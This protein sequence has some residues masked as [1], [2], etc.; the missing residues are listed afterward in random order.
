MSSL[1]LRRGKY[2][3]IISPNIG[4]PAFINF[5]DF[6]DSEGHFIK[7]LVFTAHVLAIPGQH[8]QEILQYF[9]ANT[10]IQPI[11]K[12]EGNFAARRGKRYELQAVE[13]EGLDRM[14]IKEP[15][16]LSVEN[17]LA[18][19][20]YKSLSKSK[21]AFGRRTKLYE[22]VFKI[23][24]KHEL[25]EIFNKMDNSCLLCDLVYDI[26][27]LSLDKVNYHAV[28]FFDK[29]WK[30]FNFIHSTDF[31]VARRNDFIS[32]FLK[33]RLFQKIKRHRKLSESE[34]M[35]L[36]R[37]FAFKEGVQED[38]LEELR[39]AKFNFNYTLRML[40]ELVNRQVRAKILDFVLMTGDLI[41]FIQIARG[42]Y[43]YK[44]N[45]FVFLDLLLGRNKG[46]NKPPF[47]SDDEY[48]NKK[49]IL[50]P[51]FT[52]VGNH[53]Y[54]KGHYSVRMG[55]TRQVFGMTKKDVRHYTD[56]K[57]FN[58]PKALY[59]RDKFL[60][61]YF[62]YFNPNLNYM[63]KIG[64]KYDFIFLDTGQDSIAN[65]H[66]LLR[67]SPSTKGL[68]DDQIDLLRNYIK[69]CGDEKIVIAMH[70]PPISPHLTYF[71][72]RKFKKLM[73]L[74]R[75][76]EWSDLYEDNLKKY[77]GSGRLET[78]INLKYQTIMYNWKNFLKICTG[79]DREVQRKVDLILCGHAHS[80]KEF[81]LKEVKKE[82][83]SSTN[84]KFY[85][86]PIYVDVPCEI[87]ANNYREI[88]N[89]FKNMQELS[90]WFDVN[91]PFV[92]QTQAMGPLSLHYKIKPPGFRYISIIDDQI[93]K[94]T[95]FSLH[96][97]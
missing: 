22:I 49:E 39:L 62:R 44:N 38:K 34:K 72:K 87:Y 96:Y 13:I 82:E 27:N 30:D 95:V 12:E 45:F 21:N 66:D 15:E 3:I 74:D 6:L 10:F 91:K 59:S 61:Y 58:Y 32:K 71:K 33:D 90:A 26:P 69:L 80:L 83:A 78:Q 28:A 86:A 37:N 64:N 73:N 77:T 47:L 68:K 7:K 60:R 93:T 56:I 65:L 97:A 43:Q 14:D 85:I 36:E 29:N 16:A 5:R 35:F 19:D 2:P 20:V 9:Y 92:F 88:L 40:I 50:A 94:A 1:N 11:L 46:Q 48:T 79:S 23:K 89:N 63:I 24:G 4:Q 42:N 8:I 31:H 84:L 18:W 70:S 75:N 55:G 25:L 51:I 81:R 17:C 54:R 41:D 76:L 52:T 57:F 67:G 53:D